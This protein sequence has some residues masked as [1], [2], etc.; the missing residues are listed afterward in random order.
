MANIPLNKI[1]LLTDI[2][3]YEKSLGIGITVVSARSGNKK[4]HNSNK[5]YPTQIALY[6]VED[7]S[8]NGH[9]SV[10]TKINVL[11]GKSYYCNNCDIG[12]NNN[13]RH[14]CKMS[15]DL[16]GRN[17]CLKG[18]ECL[19]IHQQSQSN[20]YPSKCSQMFFCPGCKVSLKTM[21]NHKN[22]DLKN[23]IC[24]ESFCKNCNKYYLDDHLC[25]MHSTKVNNM[26]DG[27]TDMD[28]MEVL[29]YDTLNQP[30]CKHFTFYHFE[31]MQ[32]GTGE[33][34]PNLV[35]AHSLC[36]KCQDV[37]HVKPTSTC[38]SHGSRC[39]LCKKL[40]EK[41]N[42]FDG[43]PCLGCGKRQVIF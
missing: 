18:M 34:I 28:T 39:S 24:G 21:Q 42:N 15:C 37:T 27:D 20:R 16:C 8:G 1:G 5:S 30:W 3:L 31:S 13:D 22:R 35:V 14:R 23:H 32:N 11:L 36:E 26:Y 29:G 38:S 33:H 43:P 17:K 6:H 7:D 19:Y 2:P 41:G 40:N 9:F 12:Y 25:Y 10:L 4:V